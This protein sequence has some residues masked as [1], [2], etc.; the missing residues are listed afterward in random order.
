M[1]LL[2]IDDHAVVRRGMQFLLHAH[3]KGLEVG[4]ADEAKSGLAAVIDNDWDMVVL[5]ISMPGRNGMDL[6]QEIKTAKPNLPVLV[7]SGHSEKD[8]AV[9]ALKLGAAGF[10]SKLSAAE[11]LIS[12]VERVLAG[13]KYISMALAEQLAGALGGD[14]PGTPHQTLSNRELQVLKLIA[15]GQSIKEIGSELALSPKTVATYRSRIAEKMGL[16]SNVELT[17]YAIQHHL[18]E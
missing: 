6:L 11:V 15:L 1:K 2:I 16:A 8:Y 7:I 12:A 17:R 3:F 10:V 9:R 18:V 13:G 14:S 5:D 4:E